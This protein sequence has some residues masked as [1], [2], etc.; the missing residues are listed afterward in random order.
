MRADSTPSP[1]SSNSFET[2][3]KLVAQA[4]LGLGYILGLLVKRPTRDLKRLSMKEH[5][6][7]VL[8][9]FYRALPHVSPIVAYVL[10]TVTGY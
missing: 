4:M 9:A 1:R 2:V 5:F 6:L 10:A 8:G 7:K 3:R